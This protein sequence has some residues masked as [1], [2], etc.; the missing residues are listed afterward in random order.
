MHEHEQL[1]LLNNA[2]AWTVITLEQRLSMSSY[3]F[4][5]THARASYYLWIAHE[6]V[7]LLLMSFA[8]A[9]AVITDELRMNMSS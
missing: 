5:V 8:W 9:W 2:W 6:H 3:Y 7:Q 1:F 4:W